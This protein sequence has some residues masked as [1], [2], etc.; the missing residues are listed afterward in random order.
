MPCFKFLIF[1]LLQ[2]QAIHCMDVAEQ[3]LQALEMLSKKHNKA[4]L[5]AVCHNSSNSYHTL[6]NSPFLTLLILI[7]YMLTFGV[8]SLGKNLLFPSVQKV[9]VLR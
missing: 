5:H 2:L 7:V 6:L 9:A 1:V 3:S 4:I 8:A